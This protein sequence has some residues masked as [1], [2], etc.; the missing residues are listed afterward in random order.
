MAEANPNPAGCQ[1]TLVPTAAGF[2]CQA[3]QGIDLA[4]HE[5]G[6]K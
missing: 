3:V 5:F 2:C 1:L 4:K 6:K